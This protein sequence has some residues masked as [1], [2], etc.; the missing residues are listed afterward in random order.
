MGEFPRSSRF[1]ADT[2]RFLL[3]SFRRPNYVEHAESGSVAPGNAQK[4][5]KSWTA[6]DGKFYHTINAALLNDDYT[7]L[8]ANATFVVALKGAVRQH[9][10]SDRI[11]VFRGLD[12]TPAQFNEYKEG[13]SF[14]WPTFSSASRDPSVARQFGQFQFVIDAEATGDNL[15]YYADIADYSAY[16]TEREVLFY[17]YTGFTVTKVDQHN[18]SI[19]LRCTDTLRV[20]AE[21]RAC[22]PQRALNC[23]SSRAN[24]T[25]RI[26][27]GDPN[28]YWR[29]ASMPINKW[30]LIAQNMNG[31]WDS[32]YRFHHCN[33]YFMNRGDRQWEEYQG[34]KLTARFTEISR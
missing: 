7:L 18:R 12:L 1:S 33:G 6:E 10:T 26:D 25:V 31:Y 15:S 2:A 5:F 17:P 14:L 16:P 3:P 29:D 34:G 19:H 28:L 32:P 23:D 20:E 11:K 9:A 27:N 8:T 30:F 21:A 22:I 4:L 13:T 24:L